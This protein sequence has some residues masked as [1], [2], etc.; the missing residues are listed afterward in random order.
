MIAPSAKYWPTTTWRGI[1]TTP[2]GQI[3]PK[4]QNKLC[5][6]F[7]K[8]NGEWKIAHG[9]NVRI[10]AEAAQHDPVNSPRK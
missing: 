4:H 3:V 5:Y 8:T 6:V 10:A 7:T 9:Q 1:P 2:S